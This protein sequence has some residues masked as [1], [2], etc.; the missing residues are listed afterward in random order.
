VLLGGV[1][2]VL[3]GMVSWCHDVVLAEHSVWQL[4][5]LHICALQLCSKYVMWLLQFLLLMGHVS[6]LYIMCY[7]YHNFFL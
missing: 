5:E 3:T 1:C 6:I 7:H 2:L 4:M